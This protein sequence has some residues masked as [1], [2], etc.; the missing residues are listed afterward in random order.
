M[1][2]EGLFFYLSL[3]WVII[4]ALKYL[5]DRRFSTFPDVLPS[6]RQTHAAP[7]QVSLRYLNLRIETTR[8]NDGH[9][10]LSRYFGRKAL[11]RNIM[12]RFY[13]AGSIFGVLGM[14]VGIGLLGWTAAGKASSIWKY[15]Y[16][17]EE[18][19]KIYKRSSES[20]QPI[21]SQL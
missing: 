18:V 20:I 12:T 3:V 21:V 4:Y 5:Y 6:L 11:S 8:W 1:L 13:D 17:L 10:L 16:P 19:S 9:D 7:A 2:F 15:L 14:G